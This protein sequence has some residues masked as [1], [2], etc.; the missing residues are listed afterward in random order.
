VLRHCP[1][2]LLLLLRMRLHH[3]VRHLGLASVHGDATAAVVLLLHAACWGMAVRQWH[4][5]A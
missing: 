5:S 4:S 3:H 2:L 1:A